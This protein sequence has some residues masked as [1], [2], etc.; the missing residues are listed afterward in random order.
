MKAECCS[1]L[2]LIRCYRVTIVGEFLT[3]RTPRRTKQ[4]RKHSL[5]SSLLLFDD[6]F[7]ARWFS[8]FFRSGGIS[9][10]CQGGYHHEVN[11]AVSSLLPLSP[12][13][14]TSFFPFLSFFG[15]YEGCFLDR[16]KGIG[17]TGTF[18]NHHIEQPTG[19]CNAIGL[20]I[21]L[22][23]GCKMTDELNPIRLVI[24]KQLFTTRNIFHYSSAVKPLRLFRDEFF[25]QLLF[26]LSIKTL[27][28]GVS[29]P[30]SYRSLSI[31]FSITL[32]A[33]IVLPCARTIEL[34]PLVRSGIF[35]LFFL[36][37]KVAFLVASFQRRK[38]WTT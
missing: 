17:G 5:T 10:G 8:L 36:S 34:P 11:T 19:R 24:S 22:V 30:K 6:N 23:R 12:F 9:P 31:T 3:S 1:H 25:S 16:E 7:C 4:G 33:R 14:F 15:L 21:I 38:F 20:N 32:R 18:L 37:Q 29:W 35:Y 27:G 2:Y 28:L 13:I 26:S